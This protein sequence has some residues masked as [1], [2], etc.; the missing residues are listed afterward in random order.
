MPVTVTLSSKNQIV[1]SQEARKKL[2]VRPGTRLPAFVV[3]AQAG[4]QRRYLLCGPG[5]RK[6][7]TFRR[8]GAGRGPI[9]LNE[10]AR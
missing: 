3:P 1:I 6:T 10:E 4:T 5:A 2:G 8:P 9:S 7:F